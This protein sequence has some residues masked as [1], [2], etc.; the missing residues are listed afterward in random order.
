MKI[1]QLVKYYDPCQGGMETVVKNIVEGVIDCSDDISFTVYSNNDKPNFVK[2]I[3]EKNREL[4]IKEITPF[5]FKSQPLN[6]RYPSLMNIIKESDVVH[7]HYPFPT[8]EVGLLRYLRIF[9]DKKFIITWH[10]NIKNS[11]WSWIEKF[12]NPIIKKLLVR[13]DYIVVTSPKLFEASNILQEFKHKVKVISLSF[14]PK[15]HALEA[16]KA[17]SDRKFKLLFVG[18]LRKYKGVEYLISAIDDLN[19]ELSIVGNGE[20]LEL[21]KEQVESLNIKEKVKFIT[22]ANDQE[23]SIIYKNSDLFILPSINEAEAFGVV[24]LEAMAN[25]LPVINTDLDSGVPLVSLNDYSGITVEPK[26]SEG[27]K[28]AIVK[29]IENKELYEQFS[30]NALERSRLFTRKK[31]SESYI[32][33]YNA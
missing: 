18:K 11:R 26:S 20:E 4:I 27:L 10:A 5:F 15:Y 25:G 23:L 33:L 24:Q 21:L 28:T 31:M 2:Y 3:F 7:H 8:M 6:L 16:K 32:D 30:L 19:V 22:N 12:Y 14:D 17:P 13:A 29:I 1:A 9:N